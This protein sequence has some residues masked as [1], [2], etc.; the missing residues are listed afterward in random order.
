MILYVNVV[1]APTISARDAAWPGAFLV[2]SGQCDPTQPSH[3]FAHGFRGNVSGLRHAA[4]GRRPVV[5]WDTPLVVI[6]GAEPISIHTPAVALR[7]ARSQRSR[8]RNPVESRGDL[9][10]RALPITSH[11]ASRRSTGYPGP[12]ESVSLARFRRIR[13][14]RFHTG[15][16]FCP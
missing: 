14:D 13:G 8:G 11:P 4:P 6:V 10:I 5:I 3:A 2:A 9:A 16:G 15:S 1:L 7:T 12:T